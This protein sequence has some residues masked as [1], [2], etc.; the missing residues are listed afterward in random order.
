[1]LGRGTLVEVRVPYH[2]QEE[3]QN[4]NPPSAR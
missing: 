3:K 2:N 1:V 4:E